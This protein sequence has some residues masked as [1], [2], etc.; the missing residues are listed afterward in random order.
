[1]TNHG[2]GSTHWL[3]GSLADSAL[4]G[5][6]RQNADLEKSLEEQE[7]AARELHSQLHSLQVRGWR[8]LGAAASRVWGLPLAGV[9]ECAKFVWAEGFAPAVQMQGWAWLLGPKGQGGWEG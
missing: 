5:L 1:M 3:Q 6:K 9:V 8:Q 4:A 7:G 2:N